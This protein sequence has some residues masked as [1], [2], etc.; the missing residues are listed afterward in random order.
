MAM[1]CAALADVSAWVILAVVVGLM[2]G[3]AQGALVAV[4]WVLAGLIVY[5]GVMFAVVRP[6]VQRLW[7]ARAPREERED[8]SPSD[9]ELSA[10][11][12]L[13][14]ASAIATEL[15][16]IH[17][18][19]GAF[20]AGVIMPENGRMREAIA[21]PFR[22]LLTVLLLPLFFAYAGLR[23]NLGTFSSSA[24]WVLCGAMIVVAVGSKFGGS[25]LAARAMGASWRNAGALG[26]LMNARGLVEL[27]LLTLGL[28]LGII[29]QSLFTAM[30]VMALVTTA[31]AT[32][33]VSRLLGRPGR[34]GEPS[35]MAEELG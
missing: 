30:V 3:N 5:L 16:H 26:S 7:Q 15:L 10:V 25:V 24:E 9:G 6:L 20:F 4:A 28:Q 27:V 8:H 2:R 12:L 29:T 21:A 23:A 11:L 13:I 32:P 19:F 14:L 33:M 35:G 17:A 18:L 34:G 31:M 1:E 22:Q